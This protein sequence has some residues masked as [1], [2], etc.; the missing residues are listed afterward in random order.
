M[1]LQLHEIRVERRQCAIKR[2]AQ[3]FD[4]FMSS[5]RNPCAGIGIAEPGGEMRDKAVRAGN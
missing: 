2:A 3:S 5:I 4:H 1:K